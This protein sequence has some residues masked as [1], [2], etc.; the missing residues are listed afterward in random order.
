MGLPVIS[1]AALPLLALSI[2]CNSTVMD[3]P[4]SDLPASVEELAAAPGVTLCDP[5]SRP[6][7][8]LANWIPVCGYH[9]N[10]LACAT[11][12]CPP[13]ERRTY[14]NACTACADQLV[15]GWF[16][17]ECPVPGVP[18]IGHEDTP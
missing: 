13:I 18:W 8:C 5:A 12:Y 2:A 3:P 7:T 1:R 14:S 6:G 15:Y 10:R 4:R 17:G 9:D 11:S 16:E